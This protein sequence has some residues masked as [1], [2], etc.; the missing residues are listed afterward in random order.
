MNG[1]DQD[2]DD[3]AI[4]RK[5]RLERLAFLAYQVGCMGHIG[6]HYTVTY[7]MK[8]PYIIPQQTGYEWVMERL[9]R[10]K[11]CYKVFRIYPDL[12]RSLHNLLVSHYGLESS[13]HV[14]SV[15][16]LAMFL[17]MVGGPQSFS[18]VETQF[19]RSTETVHR[20]F[21]EVLNC[22]CKLA[23]HNI[24]PRDPTF[25]TVHVRL[26]EEPFWPHFKDAIGAIDG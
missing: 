4:K 7:L 23:S 18:Q 10:K 26:K 12:F 13:R 22:L 20:K 19:S 6:N 8:E 24:T 1:V 21:K 16:S 3:E 14:T 15:E 2:T 25:T 11:S 9:G 17:W 5:R